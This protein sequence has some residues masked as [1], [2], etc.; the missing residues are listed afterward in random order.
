MS[1]FVK[2]QCNLDT[3]IDD[4]NNILD[5]NNKQIDALLKQNDKTYASFVKP[6]QIMDEKLELFFTPLSHLNS[7]NNSDDTQKTYSDALPIITEYSTNISQNIDIYNA[8]KEIFE[9]EKETL[10]HE[11]NRV[12]ELNIQGFELS[13]AHLDAETKKRL[14]EINIKKSELQNNFSQ[15][16]LNATNAYEKIITNEKDVEGIPASDLEGAKFEEDGVTKYRFTLQMPSYIAYMTYG[17]NRDI[18]EEIYKAYVSRAPQNAQIIDEL[19]ALRHEMSNLLGFKNY[20]EYSLA[21]K[22]ADSTDSVLS[23]LDK[24]LKNSKAQAKEELKELQNMSE[25]KLES[26]D[27]AFY[28]EILKKKKYSIDEEEFRPYFEQKSVVNGMFEFLNKL[29]S[30]EFKK[31]DEELWDEKAT[32]YDLYVDNKLRSRLYFDL[33][34]RKSKRGGAWMHNF[35]THSTDESGDIKLASAFLVCNFPS[36]TKDSPSLLRHDDVVTLFHEMGHA[37]HHVLSNVKESEVSGVNGVEWDAVEFPSQF[38][39]NFAYEPKVLKMFAKHHKTGEV[40]PDEM[41]QKLV[42]SKNFMSA[43][44]MLRQLEFSIFDFKLHTK[45][46]KGNE[47]QNL[48]NEIREETAL[49]QTPSYN[50]FQNGFAHIFAGGYAAGYYS[51]KW[52]EVLSADAFFR[53]VDEGIFDSSTA[54]NYLD[55]VLDGGGAKSMGEYFNLLMGRDADTDSLLRLNGIK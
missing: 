31:V 54:K 47:V 21:S 55:I 32:S 49:I 48:L 26:F 13:G 17:P 28:S 23:F 9:N 52:A 34:A 11:Q 35:Q 16:L 38:L 51:Y 2:F 8:Y 24:L 53:V 12:L 41:I 27:S 3:F 50:K 5:A 30:I 6:I 10:N 36:S 1:K 14:A 46:Y 7:V 44:G 40:I 42:D 20:S 18:R 29:F 45:A 22:M 43:S 15:N 19:L 4:L 37:I 33:E 39:E 25:T